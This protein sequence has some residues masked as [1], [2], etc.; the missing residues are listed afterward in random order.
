MPSQ[1]L[2]GIEVLDFGQLYNGPY[3]SLMLSY[4]GADVIKVEPPFGEP[5]RSRVDEGEPPEM[6]M[7]NSSKE[8]ITL[9]LKSERGKE[10]LKELIKDTDVLVENYAV[11][12][13]D[14]LGLG[15][16]TLSEV[17]PEL[18]YAHGSGF[19]EEGEYSEYTAMDLTI[20]A[21][22]GVMNVTGFPDGPPVK[23]GIAVA[24]FLGG[25]HLATGVLAA[26]YERE[27]TGEG[28]FVEVSMHDAVYPTL[29]S[30]LAAHYHGSDAPPRT[31]NRHSGLAHCP[32]NVYDAADGY[33]AIFCV[34]DKH[35][36]R[37][38]G[39]LDREDLKGDSRYDTNLKR[40][41]HMDEIDAMIEEETRTL[42]RDVIAERLRDAEVPC[43]PVKTLPEVADDP[44]LRERG[45]IQR[46]DHPNYDGEINAHGSPIRLSNAEE[47]DI[48]PSPTK[49]EDNAA[50]YARRL[51]LSEA[52]IRELEREDII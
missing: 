10:I 44:H 21:I 48:T 40:V 16:E 4:L 7:I 32:Y 26:L 23:A 39:V 43:G 28:Q 30:P 49:G 42:E 36:R 6:V 35:W 15:Y 25:I 34:T 1:P 9:D 31:G 37:L 38:L 8:G 27:R 11:G 41:E 51:G 50:V 3:C 2:E 22:G 18:V 14:D 52:E 5:L 20:Q 19:G 13:M 45:M 12:T 33:I 17:N 47:P 29:T 46:V 24:D